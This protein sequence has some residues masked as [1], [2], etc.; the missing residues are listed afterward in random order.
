MGW[1]SSTEGACIRGDA[2]NKNNTVFS[3]WWLLAYMCVLQGADIVC[4]VSTH[5]CDVA[6]RLQ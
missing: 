1:C 2:I 3:S 4:S 6:L 5:H